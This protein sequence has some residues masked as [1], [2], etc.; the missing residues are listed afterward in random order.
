MATTP[1]RHSRTL[2]ALIALHAGDSLGA[3][4]E[5]LSY[6]SI[7]LPKPLNITGGGHFSW[8][9]G[10]A[11]DDTDLTRAVLLAYQTHTNAI[12]SGK[13]KVPDIVVEAARN[14]VDWYDG[15]W[16]GRTRGVPPRDV[17]GATA[18]GIRKFKA[19]NNVKSGAGDGKA[20]NGSLMRCIPTA[21]FA[22]DEETLVKE[23][24]EIGGVTHDDLHAICA[25]VGYNIMV[26]KLIEGKGRNEAFDAGIQAV[27]RYV[28]G[29][30]A[31]MKLAGSRTV[32]AMRAGRDDVSLK[33]L[34]DKGPKEARNGP[35]V[36]PFKGAG[37]VLE[38]LSIAVA[39]LFDDR[40]L[41]D[42]LVDVVRI[43]KDTDTNAAIAGGFL[44]ARDGVEAVPERW[45]ETLQFGNEFE[46]TVN[47]ILGSE[48]G[49]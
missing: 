6:D 12:R 40:S 21:L 27:E 29:G 16:P 22:S 41:E 44:G 9:A 47:D 36:L 15:R 37:Y 1:T 34:A 45:R 35:K 25:C 18:I 30:D 5:F 26:R 39:A 2:G 31:K 4:Y 48:S 23:T 11:T 32:K 24:V 20:G 3:T 8:P 33:E 38:S 10:H 19:T 46:E 43:G 13:A 49:N 42:A 14:M 17:G 28:E 7:R